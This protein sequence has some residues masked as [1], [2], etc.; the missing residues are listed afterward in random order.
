VIGKPEIEE[1]IAKIARV[2]RA[3]SRA[4]TATS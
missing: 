3:T 2:R 4:T 1:I